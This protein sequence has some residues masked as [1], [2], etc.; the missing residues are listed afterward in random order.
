MTGD[1]PA[2]TGG[3][4]SCARRSTVSTITGCGRR[5]AIQRRRLR[6]AANYAWFFDRR[7]G[8]CAHAAGDRMSSMVS[9]PPLP[10]GTLGAAARP[11][12]PVAV[13]SR[14][15]RHLARVGRLGRL[16]QRGL[17]CLRGLERIAHRLATTAAAVSCRRLGSS[18]RS[19]GTE[20]RRRDRRGRSSTHR[21]TT[22]ARRLAAELGIEGDVRLPLRRRDRSANGLDVL[23]DAVARVP[24]T[25]PLTVRRRR[26]Q[27]A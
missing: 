5:A 2:G 1:V 4:S 6:R 15:A 13:A 21:S 22:T 25:V 16:A 11:A 12:V 24:G 8:P 27:R 14:G 9:S 3:D 26:R 20:P 18:P 19:G 7:G 10:V 17:A 23:V